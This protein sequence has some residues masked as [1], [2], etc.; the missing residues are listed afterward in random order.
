MTRCVCMYV[1]MYICA[2][3]CV[4]ACMYVCMYVRGMSL[5][6]CVVPSYKNEPL[7]CPFHRLLAVNSF[8]KFYGRRRLYV[9]I[10]ILGGGG[11]LLERFTIKNKTKSFIGPFQGMMAVNYFIKSIQT[12]S[13]A[14]LNFAR[15][16]P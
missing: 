15:F 14:T 6:C 8:L 1:C 10:Y 13:S 5:V 2:C 7:I 11:W 9:S 16:C 12:L 4:Y 3:M